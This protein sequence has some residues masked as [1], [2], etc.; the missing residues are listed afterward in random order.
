MADEAVA[1]TKL[2]QAVAAKW[3]KDSAALVLH[4]S[5]AGV[6]ADDEH[7]DELL[8][9]GDHVIIAYKF[10][11]IWPLPL[12]RVGEKWKVDIA[13]LVAAD[14]DKLKVTESTIRQ[15]TTIINSE[16]AAL[17]DGKYADADQ[18]AKEIERKIDK[19]E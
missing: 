19:L 13:A 11:C 6:R 12:V 15:V 18:L 17:A 5:G 1:V 3:G 7:A 9:D 16:T 2:E 14:G 4:A 8:R 10:A